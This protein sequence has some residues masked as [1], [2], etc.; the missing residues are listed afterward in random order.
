MKLAVEQERE[1]VLRIKAGDDKAWNDLFEAFKDWAMGI[2]KSRMSKPEDIQN[3]DD[4]YQDACLSIMKNMESYDMEK[5]RFSTYFMGSLLFA[6]RRYFDGKKR[7][8]PQNCEIDD[9]QIFDDAEEFVVD[10]LTRLECE[11]DS[12]IYSTCLKIL[13]RNG[14]AP[15]QILS[16]CFNKLIYPAKYNSNRG[17]PTEIFN[18]LSDIKLLLLCDRFVI[19]YGRYLKKLEKSY[20]QPMYIE[21]EQTEGD[22]RISEKCLRNY[23]GSRP[24]DNISDWSYRVAGRVK[25]IVLK[26]YYFLICREQ[27]RFVQ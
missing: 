3:A 13:F 11:E 12:D 24:K 19:E 5:S 14:G 17:Y 2:I 9:N 25:E 7:S 20:L 26:K 1:L 27:A 21:M 18:E 4:I 23:Y 22:I 6:L 10:A 15:H 8:M 16:F